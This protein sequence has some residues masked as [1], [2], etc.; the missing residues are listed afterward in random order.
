MTEIMIITIVIF[1]FA[2]VFFGITM[3]KINKSQSEINEHIH[4]RL[5]ALEN[6]MCDRYA[7]DAVNT[8]TGEKTPYNP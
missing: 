6:F 1:Q 7:F 8:K 4:N 5:C 2:V 3:I